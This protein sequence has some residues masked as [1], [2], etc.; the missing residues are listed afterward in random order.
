MFS[1]LFLNQNSLLY[2]YI[3]REYADEALKQ[4]K[5]FSEIARETLE[6][7]AA[8]TLQSKSIKKNPLI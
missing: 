2:I 7:V 4:G 8:D 5:V 1:Y 6:S 3:Y